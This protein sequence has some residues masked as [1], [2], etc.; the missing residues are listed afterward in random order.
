MSCFQANERPG[1]LS[2]AKHV[3]T[4]TASCRYALSAAV[5]IA[6]PIQIYSSLFIYIVEILRSVFTV[7]RACAILLPLRKISNERPVINHAG[8]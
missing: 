7:R 3:Q 6:I 2:H 5:Q 1:T 8:K 4:F